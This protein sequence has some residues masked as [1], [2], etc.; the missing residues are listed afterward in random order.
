M[1]LAFAVVL[2]A[3]ASAL[4]GGCAS[5]EMTQ[6]ESKPLPQPDP[7]PPQDVRTPLPPPQ[8][9]PPVPDQAQAQAPAPAST[10]VQAQ[11]RSPLAGFYLQLDTGWSWATDAGMKNTTPQPGGSNCL[12]QTPSPHVCTGS[13]NNLGSSSIIG[14]GVGYRLPLGFRID[15]TY[16]YRGGYDLKGTSPNNV[17]FDPKTTAN[18][19][20]LNGYYGIPY[21]IAGRVTPYVGGGI[22]RSKNK[23]NDINYSEAGPPP[24]S[25]QVPGGSKTST[26]WQLTLGADVRVTPNWVIAIGYRYSDLGTLKTK[27]GPATAGDSFNQDNFT[28]PLKGNLRAN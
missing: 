3:V 28:T 7:R 19:V 18:T 20:M 22:G 8:K 13:L 16:N 27:A 6:A 15:V 23:V 9:G 2:V 26:A 10:P 17:K 24:A 1:H 11:P 5:L 14:G 21:T 25:G 12:L 4:L